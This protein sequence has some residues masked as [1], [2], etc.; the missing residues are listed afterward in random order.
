VTLDTIITCAMAAWNDLTTLRV[1]PDA[2][3]TPSRD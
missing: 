2:T 3:G 1:T